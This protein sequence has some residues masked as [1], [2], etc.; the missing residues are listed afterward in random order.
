[1]ASLFGTDG[2]RGVAN[3]KLTPELALALGRAGAFVLTGAKKRPRFVVGRDTRIS[4]DMLE[5]AFIAGVL[6]AGG[7]VLTAGILPTPAVAY[8]TR[9]VGAEAGVMISASHNPVPDNGIKFFSAQGYKL[10]AKIEQR[11]G[12]LERNGGLPRP[13]GAGVGKRLPLEQGAQLYLHHLAQEV[14][15]DLRPLTIAVDTAH[16]AAHKVAPALLRSLGARLTVINSDPTGTNINENCGSTCPQGLQQAVLET[17]ANIGFAFDGDADRVLAVD[18]KGQPVDGDCIL[19]ILALRLKEKGL[20][21]GNGVVATAMSNMGLEVALK[22]QGI[23]LASAQVGDRYVLEG[24]QQRGWVLGG[25]QSGHIIN[26]RYNTTGDGLS[27]ALQLLQAMVETGLPL[28]QLAAVMKPLPQLLVNVPVST[29]SGWQENKA[30]QTA[31]LR[32][33]QEFRGQGRILIRPSGTEPVMR[34]MAEGEKEPL[35]QEW[36]HKIAAVIEEQLS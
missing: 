9:A 4:G 29:K 26:L 35:L 14:K 2:V 13:T 22:K 7:D 19:A 18:E 8:L 5:A 36:V 30:I 16:G 12:E 32:A 17:G 24:L 33:Q 6:S 21:P 31:I 28:S 27:T 3:Q 10:P 11:I 25:E 15:V 23:E 20:L 1:L 34:V